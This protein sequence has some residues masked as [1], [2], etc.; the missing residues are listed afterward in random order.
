MDLTSP[1]KKEADI[2]WASSQTI[3]SQS[4][5]LS[6]AWSV[7]VAA[8]LVEAADDQVVLLEPVARAGRFELVVRQDLERQVEAAVQ[9][10]LPLLGEI[11][12]ADDQAALQVA[13]DSSS[14]M[15]SPRHD[16]LAG[17]GIIGQQEA[18]RLA[19]Q[20]LARRRP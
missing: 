20:H 6:F 2:L 5:C 7:F 10:V 16:R 18:E 11:A 19:G 3:R 9:F 17:A 13:A 12:G 14:L 8:E 4:V 15:S 1:P